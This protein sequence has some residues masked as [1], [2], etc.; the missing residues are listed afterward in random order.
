MSLEA[1]GISLSGSMSLL[2]GHYLLHT[3]YGSLYLS[4]PLS[5]FL[6]FEG[7]SNIVYLSSLYVSLFY[8]F[9]YSW[10]HPADSLRPTFPTG[11]LSGQLAGV[12]GGWSFL[13]SSA[14]LYRPPRLW[15]VLGLKQ[16]DKETAGQPQNR[17]KSPENHS[18]TKHGQQTHT[19]KTA[20]TP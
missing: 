11:A 6:F 17:R 3:L 5:A 12:V 2:Y 19:T 8:F 15:S 1:V 20:P 9:E 10:G 13:G 4:V 16:G 14:C 7:G 18:D